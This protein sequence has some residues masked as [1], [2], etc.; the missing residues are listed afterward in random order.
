MEAVIGMLWADY[1]SVVKAYASLSGLVPSRVETRLWR[2]HYH[3]FEVAPCASN[4]EITISLQTIASAQE[5]RILIVLELPE[6]MWLE[7][8]K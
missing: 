5:L 3:L 8:T 1:I 6:S 2:K 4:S 7:I